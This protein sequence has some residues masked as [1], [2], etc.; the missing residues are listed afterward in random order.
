MLALHRQMKENIK[1]QNE[2]KLHT[3]MD[4]LDAPNV[5]LKSFL[6]TIVDLLVIFYVENAKKM[7]VQWSYFVDKQPA[8]RWRSQEETNSGITSSR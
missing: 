4:T 1:Q 2:T 5:N 7:F 6:L 3:L 8:A